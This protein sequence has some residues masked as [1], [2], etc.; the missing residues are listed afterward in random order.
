MLLPDHQLHFLLAFVVSQLGTNYAFE[1]NLLAKG[2]YLSV[3]YFCSLEDCNRQQRAA[4]KRVCLCVK[5]A[6][7]HLQSSLFISNVSFWCSAHPIYMY[8]SSWQTKGRFGKILVVFQNNLK[9]NLK[10]TPH[11]RSSFRLLHFWAPSPSLS[12][13]AWKLA[14]L[15]FRKTCWKQHNW[16]VLKPFQ[17]LLCLTWSMMKFLKECFPSLRLFFFFFPL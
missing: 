10:Q 6:G 13:S 14:V 15:D 9:Q 8:I 17:Q 11:I 7:I 5:P 3:P 2:C 1:D 12:H 4:A 16:N